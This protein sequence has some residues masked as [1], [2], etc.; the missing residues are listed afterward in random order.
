LVQL[1]SLA[2]GIAGDL[3]LSA[4][5]SIA[6]GIEV[7]EMLEV[8]ADPDQLYRI[9]SNLIVNAKQVLEAQSDVGAA[10]RIRLA[11]RRT[12]GEVQIDVSDSGP[13]VPEQARAHLFEAF[14]GSARSG[15]TGLGL[16]IVAEL[17]RAHGGTVAL[18]D[19]GPGTTFRVTIPQRPLPADRGPALA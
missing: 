9:L 15:G 14:Q 6:F 19:G 12:A 17:T 3:G 11:A 8:N 4:A 16:A 7:P 10:R 18:V 5:G 2:E 1:R 13:G